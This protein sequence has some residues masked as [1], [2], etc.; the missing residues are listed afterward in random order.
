MMGGRVIFVGAVHEAVPALGVL[1]DGDAEIA[2][3]VTLPPG[4]AGSTSGFVD[5][6]PLARE[7]GIPVRRCADINSAGSVDRVRELR[8]DLMVVTG[9]TRLL[10][11][12][13]LGVPARGVVGFHASLLPHYR[14]RAPVNWAILRGEATAGNTMMYLDPGVDTGDI[15]D[16]QAVPITLDDTC[17][18]VYAKVGEAGA[19]MLRRHLPGLLAG[20]APRRPQGT[21]D[22]PP[23]PKR[24]PGM[25]ITDWNRP[26]RAVHDWI[27]ALTWPYPGAFTFLAERKVMLWAAALGDTGAAGPAGDVLGWDAAGVRVGTAD[28]VILVTSMSDAGDPPGPA[29]MWAER[30]GLQPGDRFEPVARETAAW[31]LGLGPQP[32]EDLAR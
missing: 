24:T 3:V 7:H 28:G 21:G 13:L 27:R 26:A 19:D 29:A 15:I 6:E 5:L 30:S 25:G 18:S 20:T 16:Q 2:E 22:G 9:W 8:P 17:A 12:E 32:A 1:I 14:G 11:A 4:R 31:A 10:S 23:L